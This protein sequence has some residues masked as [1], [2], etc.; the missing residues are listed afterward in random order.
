MKEKKSNH[1]FREK[2]KQKRKL[3]TKILLNGILFIYLSLGITKI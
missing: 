3:K 2:K 1:K